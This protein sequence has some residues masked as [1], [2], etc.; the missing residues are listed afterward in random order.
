MTVHD[1][2]EWGDDEV[3][4][5]WESELRRGAEGPPA[6]PEHA[7]AVR[8][9]RMLVGAATLLVLGVVALVLGRAVTD[10][11]ADDDDVPVLAGEPVES[12]APAAPAA[13]CHDG[14][15]VRH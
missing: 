14:I 10:D 9:V 4:A 2:D 11:D 5:T 12:A 1:G 8:T 7:A 13:L 3:G 6:D 15:G